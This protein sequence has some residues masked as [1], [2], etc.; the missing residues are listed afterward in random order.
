MVDNELN[1]NFVKFAK[2]NQELELLNNFTL[3]G[4]LST[5]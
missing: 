1:Q 3:N 4:Y 5:H 2:F